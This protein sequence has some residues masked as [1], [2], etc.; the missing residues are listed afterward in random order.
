VA[1]R[2]SLAEVE[3]REGSP[4]F[5]TF[6]ICWD[7]F[8]EPSFTTDTC[9]IV[10][11]DMIFYEM[12]QHNTIVLLFVYCFF[13]HAFFLQKESDTSSKEM[14]FSISKNK[15]RASNGGSL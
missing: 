12:T 5:S 8:C 13:L 10:R 11:H 1:I 15:R 4:T 7:M 2:K 6:L 9:I 3:T 14:L